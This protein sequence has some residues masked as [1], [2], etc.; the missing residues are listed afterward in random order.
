M[1]KIFHLS[2]C[3]KCKR[4]LLEVE[5]IDEYVLVDL[6]NG[7]I[8]ALSLNHLYSS[9]KS[10]EKLFNKRA[11]KFKDPAIKSSIQADKD[12]KDWILKEYT[13]LKR[14]IRIEDNN[15]YIENIL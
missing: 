10:Y 5:N 6:K 14:P 2:S 4:K 8:D 9:T 1:K 3:D 12:Y 11:Q 7:P 13:F 15:V